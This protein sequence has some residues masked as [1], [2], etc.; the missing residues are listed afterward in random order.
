MNEAQELLPFDQT[1]SHV[2][3]LSVT[4]RTAGTRRRAHR[5]ADREGRRREVL[6]AFGAAGSRGLTDAEVAELLGWSPNRVAPRRL[7]LQRRNLIVAT[8]KTRPTKFGRNAVVWRV[9]E[10]SP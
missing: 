1:S 7:E 6:A 4:D 2:V 10:A 5:T 8:G 3:R 9:T